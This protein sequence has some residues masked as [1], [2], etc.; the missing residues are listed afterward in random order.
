MKHKKTIHPSPLISIIILTRNEKEYTRLCIN[1]IMQKTTNINY[2]LVFVDNGSTDGTP[3]YLKSV[4]NS[5]VILNQTN[6]GFAKGC[7]QGLAIANGE[8][9]VLLNND[10]VVTE[11]WLQRLLWH[12]QQHKDIGIVGPCSNM[13]LNAQMV[14]EVPYKGLNEMHAFAKERAMRYNQTGKE[15]NQLSGLCMMFHRSLIEGI[16]GLDTRFHPGYYE[17]TDFSIRARIYG[18]KLWVAN[19]VFIHHYGSRSFKK[20]KKLASTSVT[21]NHSKILSKWN[22]KDLS[23]IDQVV[24]REQPFHK[25]RHFIPLQ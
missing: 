19:D 1:S 10:T 17:D 15:V 18:K 7:N 16:G 20:N 24:S 22:I 14:N 13:I 21:K 12:L 3:K 23:K 25:E 4:P 11:G 2:E 6:K 8:Y 5:K 9:F